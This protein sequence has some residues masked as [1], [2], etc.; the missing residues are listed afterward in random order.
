MG[1]YDDAIKIKTAID[2]RLDSENNAPTNIATIDKNVS[3]KRTSKERTS[4]PTIN[5]TSSRNARQTSDPINVVS[6]NHQ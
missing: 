3:P 6:V 1:R 2:L 5:E 4:K